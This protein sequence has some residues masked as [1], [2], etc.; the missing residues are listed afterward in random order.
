MEDAMLDKTYTL[1][2]YV[3]DAGFAIHLVRSHFKQL[4]IG[5]C[6]SALSDFEKQWEAEWCE[7]GTRGYSSPCPITFNGGWNTRFDA[8]AFRFRSGVNA[9]VALYADCASTETH[10]YD[11]PGG[12]GGGTIVHAV[13][14]RLYALVIHH[15]ENDKRTAHYLYCRKSASAA[16]YDGLNL[17]VEANQHV[18][19]QKAGRVY[20][21]DW[22]STQ[23]WGLPKARVPGVARQVLHQTIAELEGLFGQGKDFFQPSRK[24][25]NKR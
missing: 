10:D 11:G 2:T 5:A 4:A 12:L 3:T 25:R 24:R 21:E 19:K 15:G 22:E 7:K 17:V 8:G 9:V 23:W 18:L 1:P 6:D 13:G 14:E 20:R 16:R